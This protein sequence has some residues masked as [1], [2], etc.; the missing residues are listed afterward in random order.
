MALGWADVMTHCSRRDGPSS[1]GDLWYR[2]DR[3]RREQQ[4]VT[5]DKKKGKQREKKTK[6]QAVI[7]P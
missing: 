6:D 5:E 7:Y 3:Y 4:R 2:T 1:A